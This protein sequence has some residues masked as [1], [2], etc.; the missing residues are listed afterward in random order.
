MYS[1]QHSSASADARN[2]FQRAINTGDGFFYVELV[3]HEDLHLHVENNKNEKSAFL[4][5]NEKIFQIQ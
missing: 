4:K 3:N 2:R 1:P 5:L